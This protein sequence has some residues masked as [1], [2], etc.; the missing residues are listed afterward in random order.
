MAAPVFLTPVTMDKQTDVILCMSGMP[1]GKRFQ[2]VVF[3][4]SLALTG[5]SFYYL[6]QLACHAIGS[7]GEWLP[8]AKID[9]TDNGVRYVYRLRHE[10]C[11]YPEGDTMIQHLRGHGYRLVIPA[12]FIR[13]DLAR[14]RLHPD[15]RVR[16]LALSAKTE[17]ADAEAVADRFDRDEE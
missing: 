14:L 7:P 11:S 6:M 16:Q 8:T 5:T 15:A 9:P 4:T 10:L 12:Q 3:G 2:I 17:E 1:I 13:F